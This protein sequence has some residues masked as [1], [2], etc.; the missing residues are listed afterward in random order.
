MD[1]LSFGTDFAFRLVSTELGASW[2]HEYGYL[3]TTSGYPGRWGKVYTFLGGS[4]RRE[5]SDR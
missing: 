3:T 2:Y 1:N 5:D 4:I